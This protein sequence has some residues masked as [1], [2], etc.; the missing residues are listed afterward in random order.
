MELTAYLL[1]F[2]QGDCKV[3]NCMC[4]LRLNFMFFVTKIVIIY[5]QISSNDV[6]TY[7]IILKWSLNFDWIMAQLFCDETTLLN[8]KI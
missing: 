2:V 6:W 1:P 4:S 8:V 7:I 3:C 5:F